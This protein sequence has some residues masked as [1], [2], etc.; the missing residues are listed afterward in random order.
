VSIFARSDLHKSKKSFDIQYM[1]NNSA[2][3]SVSKSLKGL[4]IGVICGGTSTEHEVSIA[5]GQNVLNSLLELGAEANLI[6]IDKN[7]LWS[8]AGRE[9]N[10]L[11]TATGL[12]ELKEMNFDLLFNA[13]HGKFGEDGQL[14]A[15]LDIVQI[16]YTGCGVMSSSIGM[17]KDFTYDL[18][19][20][21]GIVVPK[22]ARTGQQASQQEVERLV[23][24]FSYPL[25]VKPNDGG[26]SIGV[27]LV[28]EAGQLLPAIQKA[29]EASEIALIQEFVTGVEL[30]C[31]VIG[32]AKEVVT[33]LPVGEIRATAST[34]FDYE[35]KYTSQAT[36]EIFPA[37]VS[38]EVQ[39][40]LQ[41]IAVQVHSILKCDSLT[42]S[43]FIYNQ[44]SG[45]IY[46]LEINTSPGMTKA[47]LCP[48]S[49]QSYGWS[50][51]ELILRICQLALEG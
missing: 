35:A 43:D 14:Q 48:K 21:Y 42:R 11:N 15:I 51:N 36:E 29:C 3:N 1:N 30:T 33:A 7:G 39:Q 26:S 38:P 25:I 40:N 18:L 23:Q 46:F 45:K 50:M 28:T 19:Q 6:T 49:A 31:P 9:L 20:N 32:K 37:T 10:V 47:S 44:E 17:D 12:S 24:G 41:Q 4:K 13:L 16:P 22:T 8:I 5:S 27:S 34:F 2:S